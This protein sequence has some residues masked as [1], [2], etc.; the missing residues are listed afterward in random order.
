LIKD[1]A[2]INTAAMIRSDKFDITLTQL[3]QEQVDQYGI[4]IQYAAL[5]DITESTSYRLFNEKAELL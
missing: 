5:I 4:D 2:V 3:L 1:L